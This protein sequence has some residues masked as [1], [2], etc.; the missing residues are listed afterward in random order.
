MKGTHWLKKKS[1]AH[2]A[3]LVFCQDGQGAARRDAS[4]QRR[5]CQLETTVRDGEKAFYFGREPESKD[6]VQAF[7]LSGFASSE[8]NKEASVT[9]LQLEFLAS[10]NKVISYSTY[11]LSTYI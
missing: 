1:S 3:H 8:A 11:V 5:E 10:T 4:V 2:E 6:A 9:V 7:I